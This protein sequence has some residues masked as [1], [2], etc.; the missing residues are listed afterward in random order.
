MFCAASNSHA[1]GRREGGGG[2]DSSAGNAPRDRRSLPSSS[3]RDE[4]QEYPK[5]Y[6]EA[7]CAV[8]AARQPEEESATERVQ[9]KSGLLFGS[10]RMFVMQFV[11][12]ILGRA[13][14]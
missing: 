6:L 3:A 1:V 11:M 4:R 12:H 13:I 2:A 7:S 9:T 10:G 5:T 14:W 8:K